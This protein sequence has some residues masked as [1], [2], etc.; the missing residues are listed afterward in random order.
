[1]PLDAERPEHDA[2][3]ET[4]ALEDGALLDVELEVGGGGVELRAGGEHR[5]EVDAVG[6]ECS[7]KRDA[8]AVR[9]LRS[10]S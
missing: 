10:S 2:E 9:E 7:G 4:E 1:M 8:V 6:G 5:V 3:R